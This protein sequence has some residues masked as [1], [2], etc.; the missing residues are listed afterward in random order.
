VMRVFRFLFGRSSAPP[1]PT[2]SGHGMLGCLNKERW[3]EP[4]FYL[5]SPVGR[6]G[7][8]R[9]ISSTRKLKACSP[10]IVF[11]HVTTGISGK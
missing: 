1:P 10:L 3:R 9:I 6:K 7:Y 11:F 5:A 4:L 2:G 8:T